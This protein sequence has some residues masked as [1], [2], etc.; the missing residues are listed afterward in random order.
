ML[1]TTPIK[2]NNIQLELPTDTP[3]PSAQGEE[4]IN[5]KIGHI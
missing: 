4:K 3:F 2:I 1:L 5:P